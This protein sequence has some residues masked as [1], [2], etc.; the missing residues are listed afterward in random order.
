MAAIIHKPYTL[1]FMKNFV[2]NEQASS[3]EPDTFRI[4]FENDLA[5]VFAEGCMLVTIKAVGT[6]VHRWNTTIA[7]QMY[8]NFKSRVMTKIGDHFTQFQGIIFTDRLPSPM[9]ET[10][11]LLLFPDQH[12]DMNDIDNV[13]MTWA[14]KIYNMPSSDV[15]TVTITSECYLPQIDGNYERLV[16]MIKHMLEDGSL[17]RTLFPDDDELFTKIMYC[18]G[19]TSLYTPNGLP[20]IS[21]ADEA[22]DYI[23]WTRY[24][25]TYIDDDIDTR[26]L[27]VQRFFGPTSSDADLIDIDNDDDAEYIRFILA[28]Y[29]ILSMFIDIPTWR[30]SSYD[31]IL[32]MQTFWS[33]ALLCA[34][35]D[36]VMS[37]GLTEA[38]NPFK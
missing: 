13:Q 33:Y 19:V 21:L 38:D 35:E 36:N 24:L 4:L 8:A 5:N 30:L 26:R 11:H 23:M 10:Y 25:T 22:A 16:T 3:I 6:N 12:F 9:L 37:I 32:A 29:Y 15:R 2:G 20:E 18:R 17:K 27:I 34:R 1:E 7:D 14:A 31:E 28:Q